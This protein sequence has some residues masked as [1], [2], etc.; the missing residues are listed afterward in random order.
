MRSGIALRSALRGCVW[1]AAL[2][3]VV[4]TPAAAI[5][6][7]GTSVGLL[8]LS[9]LGTDEYSGHLGGLYPAGHNSRPPAHQAAGYESAR[10]VVPLSTEGQ[11]DPANGKIVIVSVGMSNTAYEFETFTAMAES[12]PTV[13]PRLAFVNGAEP[14]EAV[15]EWDDP[16]DP[17]WDLLDSR[18]AAR[19]VTGLQVQVAWVKLA[20]RATEGPLLF[21]ERAEWLRDRLRSVVQ[22]LGDRYPNLELAYLSSRI[23]AGYADGDLSPEPLAYQGGFA[24]KWLIEDQIQGD[25]GLNF[26]ADLGPVEA[27]WL[28]WAAYLWADGLGADNLAGGIPGRSDGLEYACSDFRND[29]VHPSATGRGKVAALLIDFFE[30]DSTSR[31]WF[32]GPLFSDGFE[33]GDTSAWSSSSP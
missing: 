1:A 22:I 23:Y 8:P 2:C 11:P 5:D 10:R 6:C 14:G 27:P 4:R 15:L 9:D 30:R 17:A 16:S 3:L 18:L 20:A 13:D 12:D 7:T 33:S 31:I 24:V 26:D 19:G 28:S 21:P 25:P 32:L 29:G